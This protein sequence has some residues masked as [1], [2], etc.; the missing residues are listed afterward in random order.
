MFIAMMTFFYLLGSLHGG[1]PAET[2]L[3][4]G[5]GVLLPARPVLRNL[6]HHTGRPAEVRQD[7]FLCVDTI[8]DFTINT[9]G[10]FSFL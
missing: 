6:Y 7:F 2:G 5:Q 4:V 1:C 10:N 3:V 8:S 9:G